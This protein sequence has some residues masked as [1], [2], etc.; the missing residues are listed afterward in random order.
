ML[1]ERELQLATLDE[2]AAQARRGEGRL[3]L[4][5]G[6]AGVGKSALLEEFQRRPPASAWY[7]GACDGLFTPRPLGPLLD[8]AGQLGGSLRAATDRGESREEIFRALLAGVAASA[9]PPGLGFEDVHWADEATLDLLRFLGKR[10]RTLPVLVLVTY[11]DDEIVP[12]HPLR[13]C[14]A[15]LATERSTRRVDVPR[16]TPAAVRVL[17]DG[18]GL[19]PEELHHL[20]SGN[21]FFLTEVLRDPRNRLPA[22]ARESVLGRVDGLSRPARRAL[23]TAALLGTRVDLSLLDEVAHPT[24]EA[25]DELVESGLLVP[26][27]PDLR[28]RHEITRRAV[29][30]TLPP[31]RSAPLHGRILALLREQGSDDDARLAY[32]AEGASDAVAAQ[33]HA[34]LAAEYA[35]SL[36]SHREAATQYERALRWSGSGDDQTRA[37]LLDG[38]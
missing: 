5:S 37:L 28:V 36:G 38:L 32:H 19:S 34:T 12:G 17:A 16:L 3:V 33:A 22:S 9:T 8:I 35:A 31:H 13:R 21:P 14:L 25:V 30:D 4:V 15:Q 18:S 29:E 11:R 1:L 27:G 7:W 2:Y 10:M 24:P 6:E 26:D 23:D 20:T